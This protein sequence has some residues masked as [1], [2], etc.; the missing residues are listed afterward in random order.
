MC[1]VQNWRWEPCKVS[2]V[3]VFVSQRRSWEVVELRFEPRKSCFSTSALCYHTMMAL[4]REPLGSLLWLDYANSFLVIFKASAELNTIFHMRS[5]LWSL[6]IRFKVMIV[7][8]SFSCFSLSPKSIQN[9]VQLRRFEFHALCSSHTLGYSFYLNHSFY[10]LSGK[11]FTCF[12]RIYLFQEVFSET[13]NIRAN[14]I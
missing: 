2:T 6:L 14:Y 9:L 11:T 5:F 1:Q 10:L 12:L 4:H 7:F 13:K 8:Q 3:I